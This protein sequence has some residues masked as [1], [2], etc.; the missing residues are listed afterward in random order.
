MSGQRFLV[1]ICA[2][3]WQAPGLLGTWH[4]TSACVDR[5]RLPAC[6]NEEVVYE[7]RPR[8]PG[9][10]SVALRADK[11]VNGKRESMGEL[12]FV[13]ATPATWVAELH[14]SRVR[15]RWVLE[16][17]GDSLTGRLIDL[18]SNELVRLVALHRVA[19]ADAGPP[20]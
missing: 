10:D 13:R 2:S 14:T 4:G 16:V 7:A 3:L 9:S 12:A 5:A 8:G 1:L 18:G 6:N 20:H 11:V 17:H 15:G 19:P